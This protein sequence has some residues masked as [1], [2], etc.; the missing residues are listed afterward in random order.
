MRPDNFEELEEKAGVLTLDSVNANQHCPDFEHWQDFLLWPISG[1]DSLQL[2]SGFASGLRAYRENLENLLFHEGHWGDASDEE[3][4]DS[5]K[6]I[7]RYLGREASDMVASLEV[8]S[9]RIT[10]AQNRALRN[11][12]SREDRK[13][14]DQWVKE[15][16]RYY[17]EMKGI[18]PLEDKLKR[19]AIAIALLGI[20]A[21]CIWLVSRQS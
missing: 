20:L 6:N 19:I 13:S 15:G 21:F 2:H 16:N 14:H 7:S 5:A 11:S 9:H 18:R 12:L 10:K 1:I 8:E 4:Y 17:N 3:I